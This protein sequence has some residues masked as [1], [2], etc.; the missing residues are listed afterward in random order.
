MF[1]N[2]RG[3]S[4]AEQFWKYLAMAAAL[5][6][7]VVYALYVTNVVFNYLPLGSWFV[8]FLKNGVYY[9]PIAICGITSVAAIADK[10]M[11]FRII[12]L[13]IWVMIFLFAFFPDMFYSII[14]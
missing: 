3:S 9:G 4:R 5:V 13:A 14:K 1:W 12:V 7:T 8:E 2:K 6:M 11:I 10:G